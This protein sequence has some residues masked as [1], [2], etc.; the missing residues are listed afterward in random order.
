MSDAFLLNAQKSPVA[1]TSRLKF[2]V[3]V[4]GARCTA[5]RLFALEGPQSRRNR[6]NGDGGMG[7]SGGSAG[8]TELSDGRPAKHCRRH[9]VRLDTY[10]SRSP[11]REPDAR[12]HCVRTTPRCLPRS[13]LAALLGTSHL[14]DGD[15]FETSQ[16]GRAAGVGGSGHRTQPALSPVRIKS[17]SQISCTTVGSHSPA[18]LRPISSQ[19]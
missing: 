19:A 12:L 4:I 7:G 8:R 3:V 14:V 18:N 13:H 10:W 16:L 11:V 6:P 17:H 2:D 5:A 9:R 1:D 15:A